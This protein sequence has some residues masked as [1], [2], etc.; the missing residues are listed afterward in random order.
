MQTHSQ[1]SS[2]GV[3]KAWALMAVITMSSP[4]SAN[5]VEVG[6]SDVLDMTFA[7]DEVPRS[8]VLGS[9][10]A[11]LQT[12]TIGDDAGKKAVEEHLATNFRGG[13]DAYVRPT[14]TPGWY[15]VYKN[16][17]AFGKG[18]AAFYLDSRVT[19]QGI[20]IERSYKWIGGKKQGSPLDE[21][22]LASLQADILQSIPENRL[23]VKRFGGGTN[24]TILFTSHE[25][26]VCQ[27][28]EREIEAMKGRLDATIY[29][30]PGLLDPSPSNT[31]GRKVI[32]DVLCSQ[33]PREA[34]NRL[35]LHRQPPP[36]ASQACTVNPD[37][38]VFF[39]AGLPWATSGGMI[40]GVPYWIRE[41]L[42]GEAGADPSVVQAQLFGR[43]EGKGIF[44][45][46]PVRFLGK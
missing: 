42:R 12:G 5:A 19:I 2:G 29:I 38:Y 41:D 21:R 8:S 46:R 10:L 24:K 34:W 45:G 30:V 6:K 44:A 20:G 28:L 35:M 22:E 36:S 11:S 3:M 16:P 15:A 40:G 37:D 18:F 39:R 43:R 26:P 23:I 32:R 27:K 1:E 33:D 7:T 31:A 17:S 25:C 14:L 13:R 4:C 9:M